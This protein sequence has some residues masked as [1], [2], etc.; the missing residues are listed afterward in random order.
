MALTNYQ[1]EHAKPGRHGDGNN[2]YLVVDESTYPK[3]KERRKRW[4]L[5]AKAYNATGKNA[6]KWTRRDIGI[7]PARKG[8]VTLSEARERASELRRM[9][10]DGKDPVYERQQ[11]RQEILT[12][13]QAALEFIEINKPSWRNAKHADQWLS[14]LETHAFPH[15]GDTL[16][17][18]IGAP[19]LQAVLLP[20]WLKVPE[21]ARRVRQRLCA[22][23]DY[24]HSQGHR[25]TEAPHSAITKGLPRQPTKRGNFAAMPW[26]DVPG[27][28]SSLPDMKASETIRL[29]MELAVLTAARSGEVRGCLW[30]E[31][32]LD[33]AEWVIPATRMKA[34]IEHR[35]PLAPRAAAIFQHMKE[36]ARST[37]PDA[38]VFE[39]RK[40]GTPLSDMSLT[41]PL[42]RAGHDCT[43]H[44]FRASFRTWTSEQT[45]TPR[46]VAERAL[47]HIE[48]NKTTRAYERSDQFERRKDLM[49]QWADF[50]HGRDNV[51]KL[52]AATA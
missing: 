5:R 38:L 8:S 36:L 49:R 7:G 33:K 11:E 35:I 28:I 31:I 18:E 24:A 51:V 47:A 45:N 6:G 32:D 42:R 19:E 13:R 12:F 21:T 10:R 3:S 22:I 1:V 20:I 27:F 41:M 14:T 52:A 30:S 50:C 17:N 34:E 4:V 23:L 37:S 46:D 43:L 2:L 25:A 26:Q 15:I 48:K 29:A 40:R 16:V 39:G 44:G 9:I